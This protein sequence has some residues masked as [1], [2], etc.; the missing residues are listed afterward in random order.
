MWK[1]GKWEKTSL[2]GDRVEIGYE[3]GPTRFHDNDFDSCLDGKKIK[4]KIDLGDDFATEE[5]VKHRDL[6]WFY[7]VCS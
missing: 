7:S 6:N 2:P 3:A 5:R 1:Q 4:C